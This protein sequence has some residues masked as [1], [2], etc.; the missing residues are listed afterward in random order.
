MRFRCRR[1][2][3]CSPGI[4]S[5]ARLRRRHRLTSITISHPSGQTEFLEYS[6]H[7]GYAHALAILC[8]FARVDCGCFAGV[9]D[10][11]NWLS[12]RE[13]PAV[14]GAFS[15]LGALL[16]DGEVDDVHYIW[17]NC[18]AVFEARL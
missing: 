3:P 4:A 8:P 13:E 6:A 9:F 1:W 12:C 18:L 16:V 7:T 15:E 14:C 11:E 17:K 2:W 10:V 5:T